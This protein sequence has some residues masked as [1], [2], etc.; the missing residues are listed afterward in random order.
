MQNLELANA[1]DIVFLSSAAGKTDTLSN[2]T[3]RPSYT[4]SW[5]SYVH[6]RSSGKG[7]AAILYISHL[8]TIHLFISSNIFPRGLNPERDTDA[9]EREKPTRSMNKLVCL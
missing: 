8:L 7:C 6:L 2:D 9:E 5:S 4:G 3:S 1:A